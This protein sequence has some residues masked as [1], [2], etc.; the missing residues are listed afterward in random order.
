MKDYAQYFEYKTR[1][2]GEGF[3]CLKDGEEHDKLYELIHDIHRDNF[4]D[5]L[6]NDWVYDKTHSAFGDLSDYS[7]DDTRDFTELNLEVEP[8]I[9]TADLLEWAKYPAFRDYI[10]QANEELG[11][12]DDFDKE[13]S[14]AQWL[15]LERIYTAVWEFMKKNEK[16]RE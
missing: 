10:D 8:D 12:P 4:G 7:S 6:P 13:I 14:Q 9:Y 16:E 5:C 3:Y 2:N 11:R 15:A 1:S